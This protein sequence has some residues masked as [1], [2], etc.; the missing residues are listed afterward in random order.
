MQS[1]AQMDRVHL[2]DKLDS[3]T[4]ILSE[5][6]NEID[7]IEDEKTKEVS[8]LNTALDELKGAQLGEANNYTVIEEELSAKNKAI[9][10]L[11]YQLT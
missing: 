3:Q 11:Q 8:H 4:R 7:R 9:E 2:E 10:T 5:T 6:N 1:A